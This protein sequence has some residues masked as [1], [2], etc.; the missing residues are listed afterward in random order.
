MNAVKKRAAAPPS[1]RL[2][3]PVQY[4]VR[5]TLVGV[6]PP[7]WRRVRVPDVFTLEQ[8]HRVIQL[9]MGWLDC[10]LYLFRVGERSFERPDPESE[11]ERA[12]D[13]M[14]YE[15]KLS[16]GARLEYLYDFG[17]DWL[18]HLE[19]EAV[20]PMPDDGAYDWTPRILAGERA[21]PPEDVGGPP[22]YAHFLDALRNPA[23]PEHSHYASWAPGGFDA[24]RFDLRAVDSALTLARGW[25]AI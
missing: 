16:P 6:H 4:V 8:L 11:G 2:R 18:H 5:V 23:H 25:G 13:T 10:H 15:L 21:G 1:R 22:G 12:S 14:L 9:A 3:V 17:D 7:V 24:E 19:L 20:L